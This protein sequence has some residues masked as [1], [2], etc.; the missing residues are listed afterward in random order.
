MLIISKITHKKNSLNRKLHSHNE[1]G[2][3][4]KFLTVKDFAYSRTHNSWYLPY[5]KKSFQQLKILFTELKIIASTEKNE[6][7]SIAK[8]KIINPLDKLKMD[9]LNKP[10]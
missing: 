9:S 1:V 2:N 3:T 6:Q 5:T 10:P 7:N 4:C 8:A